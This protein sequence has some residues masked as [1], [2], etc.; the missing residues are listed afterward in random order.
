[1]VSQTDSRH[2]VVAVAAAAAVDPRIVPPV[3]D[4]Q[5]FHLKI[6]TTIHSHSTLAKWRPL[7]A[8]DCSF[9]RSFHHTNRG[10][11]QVS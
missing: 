1:M 10:V 2:H 8:Q 3:F 6:K 5:A 4:R 11:A 7:A 9:G